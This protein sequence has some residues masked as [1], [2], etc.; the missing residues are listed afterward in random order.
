MSVAP[1]EI[2]PMPNIGASVAAGDSPRFAAILKP[3]VKMVKNPRTIKE[4]Y[5]QLLDPVFCT[6]ASLSTSLEGI[7]RDGEVI[8]FS[9]FCFIRGV[10]ALASGLGKKHG[11]RKQ[12]AGKEENLSFAL[13][14]YEGL[15]RS[16]YSVCNR[17]FDVA[18]TAE[19]L[20]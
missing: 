10:S 8:N 6:F 12:S 19:Y 14:C 5:F 20:C 3:S 4:S 7:G 17:L 13:N 16:F 11:W 9:M 1:Y 18:N 2:A 15:T